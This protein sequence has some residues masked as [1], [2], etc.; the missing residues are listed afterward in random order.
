MKHLKTIALLLIIAVAGI[1]FAQR[2]Q[3]ETKKP[4]T[5]GAKKTECCS[6]MKTKSGGKMSCCSSDSTCTKD[7]KTTVG[8][9]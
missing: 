7:A 8:K 2:A 1:A 3:E 9:H 4:A 5:Q 6:K